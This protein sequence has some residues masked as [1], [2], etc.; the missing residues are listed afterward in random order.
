MS[1]I[2]DIWAAIGTGRGKKSMGSKIMTFRGR[3]AATALVAGVLTAVLTIDPFG[4]GSILPGFADEPTDAD[5]TRAERVDA[6]ID[7]LNLDTPVAAEDLTGSW[8]SLPDSGDLATLPSDLPAEDSAVVVLTDESGGNAPAA[9]HLQ[10]TEEPLGGPV[11]LGGMEVTVAPAETGDSPAAVEVHVADETEAAAAGVTGVL[12]DVTDASQTPIA[13]DPH[14][15]LTVSYESFAGLRG[16][17]WATRLRVVWI[18]DCA[19]GATDCQPVPIDTVNDPVA[20]TVTATVPVAPQVE[21]IAA[22]AFHTGRPDIHTVAEAGA[23]GS[24]AI[25]AGDSGSGG[26]WAAT[27]LSQSA[28]WS[29][30]GS[31]GGFSWSLPISVPAA[32]SGPSPQLGFSYSSAGADGRTPS[33]N[34]QSGLIGEG[35][36]ITSAY[37]ERSYVPCSQDDTGNANNADR[38]TGDQCW[39]D[40]NATLVFNGAG[41]ELIKDVDTGKWVSKSDD[42]SLVEKLTGAWNGGEANEYWKVTTTDG[43]Q[44]FFGRGKV[45]SSGSALNS[46]WTVPVYGNNPGERCYD[47]NFSDSRCTQVW[48]WNLEYVIDPLGN[49]MTYHYT[50]ETNQYVYDLE[51]NHALD[52][53]S[54]VAGG[55][56]DSIEYGT[57]DSDAVGTVAPARVTFTT[58]PRCVT[59]VHDPTSFCTASQTSTDSH[60]WPDT[61]TDLVCSSSVDCTNY[62]P[63]F[64][65]RY[66][67]SA[68]STWAYDGSAYQPIG[69]WTIGQ[70]FVAQ[71]TGIGIDHA[72]GVMLVVDSIIH[73]GK[74]GTT[75]TDDDLSLLP[76]EFSYTFLAN[77]VDS[78]G[79]GYPEL[80]RP[81][82]SNVRTDT[83]ASISVNYRTE[84]DAD[85][86]PGTTTTA[87]RDNHKLCYPVKWY[88]NDDDQDVT[89]YFHKYV[90]DTIVENGAPLANGKPD[91]LITGSQSKVTSFEY[92]AAGAAW[93]KPTGAMVKAKEVTYSDFLGYERVTTTVGVGAESSSSTSRFFRGTGET[94]T[95]G[96]S[97]DQIS[98][99]DEL[100]FRGQIFSVES[101]NGA[102]KISETVTV[103]GAPVEIAKDSKNVSAYRI[104]SST[105]YGFSYHKDDDSN[106][107][108][109]YKTQMSTTYN[110]Y[111]QPTQVEDLGDVTRASD[112]LCT[113]TTYAHSSN[114]A[115]AAKRMVA[116]AAE[117][118]VV[119][120]DCSQP[121]SGSADVLSDDVT[122]FDDD[123]RVIQSSRLDPV[124][125]VDQVLVSKTTDF[126]AKDRPLTVED[127]AGTAS[128]FSYVESSGGLPLSVTMATPDPD[129]SG[130]LEPF[131][132][133][134]TFNPL[135]GTV[136]STED[137]NGR[138]TTG[139]YDSLGR[140]LT[141]RDPQHQLSVKPSAEYAYKVSPNGLNSI[142]TKTIGADGL[143]QKV[144]AA[145]YDGLLRQ[146]QTQMEGVDSGAT[147]D[148]S[149]AERGRMVS[150]TV[151]DSAG[152][153]SEQTAQWWA[154][155]I[156]QDQPIKAIANPASETTFEYDKA[157]RTTAQILWAGTHSNPENEKWR[158]TTYYDGALTLQIPPMGGTPQSTL[159]DARGRTIALTQYARDPDLDSSAVDDGAIF[160]LPHQTTTYT[161]NAA[162]LTSEMEDPVGNTWTYGYDRL[163]RLTE[164]VDPDAGT[165][166]T[167][168]NSLDQVVARENGNGDTL[169]YEYDKLGRTVAV[170]K[171]ISVDVKVELASWEYDKATFPDG[172]RV[173][174]QLSSSSRFVGG[175]EYVTETPKYDNALRPLS[176]KVTL[177]NSPE[178]ESLKYRSYTTDFTFTDDGQVASVALPAVT[179]AD[180]FKAMGREIVTTRYD[181]ASMP[182]WMSG[183]FG[184]GTYVA[185]SRYSADG[186]PTVTDLG[187]TRGAIV[188]YDYDEVTKQILGVALDREGIDGTD[189]NLRYE[190]DDAGNV[191]SAKDQPSAIAVAGSVSQD[192]Q[193]FGYDGLQ[194]LTVAWTAL[195]SQYCV[196]PSSENAAS[197]VG[198]VAPYWTE[199]SYDQ[200]GNR[201]SMVEHGLGTA[202]TATTT[203][204]VGAGG[205]G[206]HQL[207]SL[208]TTVDAAT[209]TSSFTY[210]ASGNRASQTTGADTVSYDWNAE[211][212]LSGVVGAESDE[213]TNTY[214]ASGSRLVR[215][216]ASGTTVYLPGGQEILI[217][218]SEVSATRYYSFAGRTVAVR[219][220]TGMAGVSSLV[221]DPHGSVVAS[222]PNTVWTPTSVKRVFS[223]PFG[224]V[225]D[226]SD[227]GVPGD[228]RFLGAVRDT[229]SGLTLLGARYYDESVGQFISVDPKLDGGVPAQFNAYVYSG[230]N[231]A[232][233]S[234][235]SGM[236]WISDAPKNVSSSAKKKSTGS[237]P[238]DPIGNAVKDA[239]QRA[240]DNKGYTYFTQHPGILWKALFNFA[241]FDLG[242]D[243]V[244]KTRPDAK[245]LVGGYCDGYDAIFEFF[246]PA[247]HNKTE[248]T[249]TDSN[250]D[251][252]TYAY[253]GWK[254][255]YI[256][257]GAG[258]EIGLY[259]KGPGLLGDLG[260]WETV[261][262]EDAPTVTVSLALASAPSKSIASFEPGGE[263]NWTGV[264][265]SRVQGLTPDDLVATMT[266]DFSSNPSMR[267]ALITSPEARKNG[268]SAVPNS[269]EATLRFRRRKRWAR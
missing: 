172:D 110:Q 49:T 166:T 23:G 252:T 43:I 38:T 144:S 128:T 111:S 85:H 118:Q 187:N 13:V 41:G 179:S 165:S 66:R 215:T 150:Q 137:L 107:V 181:S 237:P 146:F 182:S 230:N 176:T 174:G 81:R 269:N 255:D 112:D 247:E 140:L 10:S 218:G 221:C 63:T 224:A 73:T 9:Y 231:P 227:A 93:A 240:V 32:A 245:Q 222:V 97:D 219:S 139:T 37:V 194:R 248:F 160:A 31:T 168:Y 251:V 74:G 125:G 98:S 268:W 89:Q 214:D 70:R 76:N 62:S 114:T 259:K 27:S 264:Y 192:N 20:Q 116:L 64:F 250:G 88:P 211:G 115:L 82:M 56:L 52:A 210:D 233:F 238:E 130:P 87:Q 129:G 265:A 145:L 103:P 4:T 21:T 96:P 75:A 122:N 104:P 201:T 86:L 42:G 178:F 205:A 90:V 171:V 61:P 68:V 102:T 113:M 6:V 28:T 162:G 159:T 244:S 186:L 148:A 163:G 26:D 169:S 206:P 225:R 254:G 132:T 65:D 164:A 266:V 228:H 91:Q 11:D 223:D 72:A 135:T 33:T 198:G 29:G 203:Y 55:R 67:L 60:V 173:L 58:L 193:C 189:L 199:Y 127:A 18:P 19:P 170:F 217:N 208:S 143:T 25:A 232:T 157:G 246:T 54:Y 80:W 184:W 260:W 100:R 120:K 108:V 155:G 105:T 202:S 117:T 77:R 123:G 195:D 197:L 158:T 256:N 153:I 17:D 5:L 154:Q 44:Y 95:A 136:A 156:P 16:G 92:A 57:S 196:T 138:T 45:S 51:G 220:G 48:R 53:L 133:I 109:E 263:I 204:T 226:G 119:S 229:G 213:S 1:R 24:L 2:G 47:A 258:T 216:D 239:V 126:D 235:P 175:Y 84:C 267:D 15:D 35:F 253:W 59:D 191:V 40:R 183:G 241:G 234:D 243:G 134:K 209:T 167:T 7:G 36:E 142:V 236:S 99:P 185:E 71:G 12:L 188:S 22:A 101:N 121:A 39:G 46:A 131:K 212:K 30:G 152:R 149:A 249:V 78:L 34:N 50:K 261:S 83:G 14:V 151:Y 141:V 161:F 94:L 242:D 257:M 124:S 8:D 177:P 190:Y 106:D 200:L 3:R 207:T 69:T 180:D 262:A 147:R 79:D